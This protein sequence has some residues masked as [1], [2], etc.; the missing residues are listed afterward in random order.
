MNRSLVAAGLLTVAAA[1]AVGL[2]A[3]ESFGSATAPTSDEV[4]AAAADVLAALGGSVGDQVVLRTRAAHVADLLIDE[5]AQEL[6]AGRLASARR[7][8]AVLDDPDATVADLSRVVTPVAE[9]CP[10]P[11]LAR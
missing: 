3:R 5:S 1:G 6:D 7:I 8:V 4:C 9:Q 2:V 11:P 10:G